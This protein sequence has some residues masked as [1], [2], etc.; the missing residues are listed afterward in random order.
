ML[1]IDIAA[2]I[3]SIINEPI[4]KSPK[5]IA[6]LSMIITDDDYNYI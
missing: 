4:K 5:I 6:D 1:P 2:I 3:D